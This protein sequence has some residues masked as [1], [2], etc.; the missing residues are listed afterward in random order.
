MRFVYNILFAIFFWVSAPWY[1]LKMSRR[2]NWR[3]GFWQR[4]GFY[5][6]H[7]KRPDGARPVVWMHAVSVG[8]V[9]ICV[10]LI[11]ALEPRLPAFD[12]VVSTTT[13]TGMGELGRKLPADIPRFYYPF[14]FSGAVR[15][16]MI[17]F[18]PSAI[19]LVENELWP[20]F[21]WQAID[22]KIPLFLVNARISDRSLPNYRRASFLFRPVFSQ[23]RAVG[24]QEPGDAGRLT[25]LG[26][27][28]EA[29]RVVGSLKFDA[30]QP[31]PRPGVDVRSLLRQIG[32]NTNAKILVAG[33][34]HAGEEAIL[35]GM[36]KRLR[37]RFPELFLVLVPRHFE[38]TAEVGRELEARGVRY[39]RRSEI[40]AGKTV[41]PGQLECLLVNS[42]GELKFFYEAADVVFVGKSLTAQGGQNPIEPAALGKA[43]VLGPNMQNFTSIVRA[44]LAATAVVQVRDAGELEN[45]VAELLSDDRRRAELGARA[46]GVVQR[47]LGATERTAELI[48]E[49]LKELTGAA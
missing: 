1:F 34:T 3:P 39:I 48:S 45:T 24:C 29:V 21:L 46:L 7:V 36:F 42:T 37:G 27:P 22:R 14:D 35:A 26:F 2:P 40:D 5:G 8:E 4:F 44:F 6:P 13:S 25:Q 28:A 15:R 10:Q 30:A 12:F 32:V 20:N 33:S 9:G 49:R 38:R 47:N 11:R 23:F 41:P 31:D 16:A 17:T 43:V 18:R 19:I